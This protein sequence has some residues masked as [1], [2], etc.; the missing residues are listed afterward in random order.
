MVVERGQVG[1]ADL[2]E[3]RASAPR[4]RRPRL[5]HEQSAAH[6]A[7][8]SQHLPSAPCS[9]H[10]ALNTVERLIRPDR[11]AWYPDGSRSVVASAVSNRKPPPIVKSGRSV[12]P[13][14]L[15]RS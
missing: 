8:P 15:T 13:R 5:P 12:P 9:V 10:A 4:F 11:N 14:T 3:P 6:A 1:W 2:D 7:L